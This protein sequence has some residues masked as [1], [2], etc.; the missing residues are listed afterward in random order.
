[1]ESA[2]FHTSGERRTHLPKRWA[3]SVPARCR[4][5]QKTGAN[6]QVQV[7][8]PARLLTR[9]TLGVPVLGVRM[10]IAIF[11]GKMAIL[12]LAPAR[13]PLGS[14]LA[15][16]RKVLGVSVCQ[17]QTSCEPTESADETVAPKPL[18]GLC[19]GPA[20][21][22]SRLLARSG[23]NAPHWGASPPLDRAIRALLL[24]LAV[25]LFARVL[26]PASPG[27]KISREIHLFPS[28][29]LLF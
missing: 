15:L 28:R 24:A 14:F 7:S 4:Y 10:V 23:Q 22:L 13:L 27:Y 12:A 18:P 19:P 20:R 8:S 9:T 6:G 1:M 26:G 2:A 11:L 29:G 17:W 5:T 3:L 21:G 25:T 16:A